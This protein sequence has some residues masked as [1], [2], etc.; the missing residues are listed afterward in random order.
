MVDRSAG[1]VRVDGV[2]N[3][4]RTMKKAGDDLADLKE[5]HRESA[6]IAATGARPL[7]PVRSGA[8]AAS[9]RSTGT[10]TAGIIRSGGARVPYAGP[11]HW[12]WP[13]RGIAPQPFMATGAE[14]TEPQWLPVYLSA[15]DRALA[16]IKGV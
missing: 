2:K 12:G 1:T 6:D 11:I 5:A 14:E 7:V 3:L 10:K 9:L 13:S 8:L 15:V 4:R 16:K